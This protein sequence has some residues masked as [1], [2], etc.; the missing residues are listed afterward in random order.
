MQVIE[1]TDQLDVFGEQHAITEH[2]AGHVAATDD[3]ERLGLN[4]LADLAE[5]AFDRFP[6]AARGDAH[7]LVVVASGA[8]G[9]EGIVQPEIVVL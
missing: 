2:I 4:I 8:A 7:F 1:R 3:R 9:G 6:S 5:M